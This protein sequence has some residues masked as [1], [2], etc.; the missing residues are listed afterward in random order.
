MTGRAL[1]GQGRLFQ[2]EDEKMPDDRPRHRRIFNVP[3]LIA[4]V[5]GV[6]IFFWLAGW[7]N[8]NLGGVAA[9]IVSGA[10]AAGIWWAW[11]RIFRSS[12]I[13]SEAWRANRSSSIA[14]C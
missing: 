12:R 8:T 7:W 4:F 1:R 13:D 2:E 3:N 10:A 14:R 11:I 6:G 9:A 5:A